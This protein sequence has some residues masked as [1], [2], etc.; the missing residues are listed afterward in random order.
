MSRGLVLGLGGA[1]DAILSRDRGP[2]CMSLCC[3]LLQLAPACPGCVCVC[4]LA[5]V[6]VGRHPSRDDLGYAIVNFSA[7]ASATAAMQALDD[8]AVPRLAGDAARLCR[9]LIL[10]VCLRWGGRL[11]KP[12]RGLATQKNRHPLKRVQSIN[13]SAR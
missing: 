5:A 11:R 2:F 12:R 1:Q 3:M 7:A 10:L 6:Y 13:G 9:L 8:R 4:A